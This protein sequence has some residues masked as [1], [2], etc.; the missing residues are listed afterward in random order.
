LVLKPSSFFKK[1]K[2]KQP[3]LKGRRMREAGLLDEIA[4]ETIQLAA[5]VDYDD[6]ATS[7][8]TTLENGQKIQTYKF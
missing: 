8:T 5:N 3:E 6:D 4:P 7:G 1:T 2:W